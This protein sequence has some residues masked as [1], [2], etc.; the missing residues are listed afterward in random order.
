MFVECFS[1]RDEEDD[2]GWAYQEELLHQQWLI[3]NRHYLQKEQIMGLL[4]KD[5]GGDF[6]PP[7]EGL[8]I[9]RC[10]AVIDLGMQM[11]KAYG[12]SSSK[13][14][15]GWELMDTPMPDGKP[16]IQ[17]QRYTTSLSEKSNLRALLEAW[18]GKGFT[19]EELQGF[20]LKSI[21]GT[22]C[23]LTTKH[24]VNPQTNKRWSEVIS[25]C[26]LPS[27]VACPPP[28]NAPLFFDLDDFNEVDYQA[29]P[30]GIR[31]KINI[32]GQTE[33]SPAHHAIQHSQ[34]ADEFNQ[35]VPF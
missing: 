19:P 10:Y 5:N 20:H 2:Q 8:H 21:L 6:M 25:I 33:N 30:E 9:A 3:E 24:K 35:D 34:D 32:P 17:M 28:F 18:R 11:N 27:A 15:I 4:V 16:F 12:N 29:L 26:R 14:L 31:Q 22:A 13:V 1:V 23:Y 7:P